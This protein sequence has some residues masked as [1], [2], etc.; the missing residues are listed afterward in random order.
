MPDPDLERFARIGDWRPGAPKKPGPY[1]TFDA[2]IS[3]G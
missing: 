3:A 2:V 1:G